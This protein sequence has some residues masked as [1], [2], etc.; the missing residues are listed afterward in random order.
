MG[1]V[2]GGSGRAGQA[3]RH[4]E[5]AREGNRGR[6]E[7]SRPPSALPAFMAF[8]RNGKGVGA[9]PVDAQRRLCALS[10]GCLRRERRHCILLASTGILEQQGEEE[11]R[12][13]S[14]A[15]GGRVEGRRASARAGAAVRPTALLP[16][17]RGPGAP[18]PSPRSPCQAGRPPPCPRRPRPGLLR[19]ALR[20]AVRRCRVARTTT[21]S[22]VSKPKFKVP[23]RGRLGALGTDLGL[24]AGWNPY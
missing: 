16:A 12:V 18:A 6:P 15:W 19:Y 4:G 11:Q 3:G 10:P 21:T 1:Q 20:S 13:I 8:S 7:R 23:G 2:G 17:P 9:E 22:R 14:Q 5:A 24:L